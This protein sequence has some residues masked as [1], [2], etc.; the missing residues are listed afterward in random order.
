[1]AQISSLSHGVEGLQHE[2]S[3]MLFAQP[4]WSR[5]SREQAIGRVWRQGQT[6]P[7]T[8]TTLICKNSLDEIV[9]S[10]VEGRAVWMELFK[11]HLRG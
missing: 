6:K 10:R 3:D 5:D 7:V 9:V 8:V 1:L 2:Y 4:P 11:E